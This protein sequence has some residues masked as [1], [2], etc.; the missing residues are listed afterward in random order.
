MFIYERVL[1]V[2]DNDDDNLFHE[3]VLRDAG[4]TGELLA[5]Q[6]PRDAL[7]YLL[8]AE[9][10]P[11]AIFVDINMPLMNGF[12]FVQK[13]GPT[14]KAFPHVTVVMLTSSSA[15]SDIQLAKETPEIDSYLV[16]PLSEGTA[17]QVLSGEA[18][19]FPE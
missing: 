7:T 8:E 10:V 11:T 19:D 15:F 14:L 18:P 5:F 16:K 12:Q 6:L 13:A 4:F 9:H 17:K 2:D 3:I 1:L